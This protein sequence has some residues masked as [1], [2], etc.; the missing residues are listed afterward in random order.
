MSIREASIFAGLPD[1]G[2]KAKP[3]ANFNEALRGRWK[4]YM[5]NMISESDLEQLVSRGIEP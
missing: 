5:G 2:P 4:K 1:P 3:S